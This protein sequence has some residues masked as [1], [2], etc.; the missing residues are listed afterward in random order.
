M[1]TL[2]G[3]RAI[4]YKAYLQRNFRRGIR[5]FQVAQAIAKNGV[6]SLTTPNVAKEGR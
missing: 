5:Q 2:T 6:Y 3:N 4:L 1:V